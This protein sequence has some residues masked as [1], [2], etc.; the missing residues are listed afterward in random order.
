MEQPIRAKPGAAVHVLTA[1]G[2]AGLGVA[3]ALELRR[4]RRRRQALE[5]TEAPRL[6][7]DFPETVEAGAVL[8]R[9]GLSVA[10]AESC[11]GGLLC[12]ALT[13]VAGSS[14]YVRGGVV[15]YANDVKSSLLG[16][17]AEL[18]E[19][20][21]A[22]S[23]PVAAAM[24]AAVRRRLAA[25]VGLAITG[26]AG[27]GSEGT[28]KPVGLVFVAISGPGQHQLVE[29]IDE[30]HGREGNRALAVHRALRLCIAAAGR[31]S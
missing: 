25:D 21:G 9:R 6:R 27:P 15:A 31:A 16:V 26:V 8:R 17:P 1:G 12:A 5:T 4:R 11:T 24:A 7:D 23:E 29:R 28:T 30:D 20:H 3:G 19:T 14:A 2:L 10:T 13:A 22:V 18:V